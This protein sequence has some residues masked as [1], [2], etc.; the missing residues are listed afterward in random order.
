MAS[1][2]FVR[3]GGKVYG[4][5]DSSKLRQLVADG[6]I[7]ESTDVSQ[8]QSGPWSPA[9]KVRGLFGNA[10]PPQVSVTVSPPRPAPTQPSH[11]AAPAASMP[12]HK[13][14]TRRRGGY[15][16]ANLLPNEDVMYRGSLHW[17]YFI[18]PLVW[19]CL[20][21]I[22]FSVSKSMNE[23]K[24][25]SGLGATIAGILA[26]IAALGSLCLR[27]I[28]YITSEF[29]VTNK[30][31]IMKQGFIRRKTLE[32]MLGKVDSLAVTQGILGRIFGYGTVRVTVAT[33]KQT[34]SF[35]ANPLEFRRQVQGR[36]PS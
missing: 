5:L 24:A 26:L 36:T 11:S 30:R 6:K 19:L 31:V 29:A 34:F 23:A 10:T 14:A 7:N 35:L 15:V 17:F 4:P 22:M 18:R 1:E 9:G 3:G 32:L 20:A 21:V 28:G 16:D 25:D 8:S 27:F 12:Q 33:E 2:W 13:S